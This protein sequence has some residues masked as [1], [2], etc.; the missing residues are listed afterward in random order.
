MQNFSFLGGQEVGEKNFFRLAGW[1]AK[2]DINANLSPALISLA[3]AELGNIHTL[4]NSSIEGII[5][6]GKYR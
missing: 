6:N 1:P 5:Q 3:W 4:N 2:P